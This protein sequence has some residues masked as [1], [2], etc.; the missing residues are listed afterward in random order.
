MHEPKKEHAHTSSLALTNTDVVESDKEVQD[1]VSNVKGALHTNNHLQSLS[2]ILGQM[3]S[4]TQTSKIQ[5]LKNILEMTK[6]SIGDGD[7]T[8]AK[9]KT[10]EIS[11]AVMSVVKGIQN[12]IDTQ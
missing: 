7:M 2:Q 12:Q 3:Q 5:D 10:L 11:E 9:E 8:N 1:P 6:K 4:L